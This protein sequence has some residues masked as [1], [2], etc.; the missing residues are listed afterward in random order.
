L[1]SNIHLFCIPLIFFLKVLA[2]PEAKKYIAGVAVHWYSD[3]FTPPVALNSFH[4]KFPDHFILATE[5]C[6]GS[7]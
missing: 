3:L 1:N 7:V 6:E 5:A 2:H 4:E